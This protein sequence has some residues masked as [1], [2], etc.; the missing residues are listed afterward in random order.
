MRKYI[1]FRGPYFKLQTEFLPVDLRTAHFALG[2]QIN[3]K[4]RGSVTY[5]LDR[6]KEVSKIFI[7]S[8]RLIGRAGRET[9]N[10]VGCTVGYGPLNWP[11]TAHILTERDN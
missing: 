1:P 10:L 6:E 3:G 2:S 4:K 11:I 5:I 9:S 8:L 7:T